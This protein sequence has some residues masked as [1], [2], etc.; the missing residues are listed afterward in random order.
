MGVYDQAGRYVIKRRPGAFFRWRAPPMWATGRWLRWLDTRTLPFPG[1][2]DRVCDTVA[3]FEHR[4]E[5]HRRCLVDVEVQAEPDADMLERLGEYALRLRRELYYGP[6]A[7]GKY[8]VLCLVVNLTGA[9]QPRRLEMTLPEWG[10]AGQWL[11][12]AQATLREESAGEALARI[13]AGELERWVLPWL[14]LLRD[15]AEAANLTVWKRLARQEPDHR[16]RSDFGALAAVFAEL[17]GTSVVWRE[18]LKRW[19]MR[20]SPQ[21]LEWQAEAAAEASRKTRAEDVR[22]AIL[23]RLGTSMPTD[24]EERLAALKREA[25]LKRWFNAALAAPSLDAFRV[26]VQNG[27]RK[28][29]RPPGDPKLGEGGKCRSRWCKSGS[30]RFFDCPDNSAHPANDGPGNGSEPA[31]NE[32]SR[33]SIDRDPRPFVRIFLFLVRGE[34]VVNGFATRCF[35]ISIRQG[36]EEASQNG[37]H[38]EPQQ[39]PYERL[40]HVRSPQSL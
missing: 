17:A 30:F 10:E 27:E 26:A 4:A 31:A 3:E 39:R 33:P 38:D 24:L 12:V 18:A 35:V 7:A 16:S 11:Q 25:D 1:E 23:I 22:Q 36:I 28:R 8:A 13:A 15:A 32:H 14:P 29:K 9:E 37:P 21:V 6:G 19:N 2:P 20:E 5:P 34:G 40:F